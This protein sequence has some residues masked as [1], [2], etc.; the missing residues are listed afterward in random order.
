MTKQARLGQVESGYKDRL[1]KEVSTNQQLE[2]V[3]RSLYFS[4]LSII[5]ASLE[6]SFLNIYRGCCV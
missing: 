3:M 2:K 6:A 1:E 5:V 4:A